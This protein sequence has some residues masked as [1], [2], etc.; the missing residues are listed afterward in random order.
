MMEKLLNE[1]FETYKDEVK[2]KRNENGC[3]KSY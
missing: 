2:F 1:T 3:E